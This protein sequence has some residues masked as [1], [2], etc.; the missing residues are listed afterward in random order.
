M[1]NFIVIQERRTP[2][3]VVGMLL[4]NVVNQIT[5]GVMMMVIHSSVLTGLTKRQSLL[6]ILI[7]GY[8][9]VIGM[10]ILT[11]GLLQIVEKVM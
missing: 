10:I 4:M 5:G 2:R 11:S 3:L 7:S 6:Q 8:V 9:G 1:R